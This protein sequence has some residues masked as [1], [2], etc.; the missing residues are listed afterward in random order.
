MNRARTH[1]TLWKSRCS[2]TE[3][4]D[5]WLQLQHVI[6]YNLN[7]NFDMEVVTISL[8]VTNTEQQFIVQFVIVLMQM[9]KCNYS[10]CL[11]LYEVEIERPCANK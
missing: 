8:I 2:D 3:A 5:S 9:S 1:L 4:V 6:S 11:S 10:Y 7:D